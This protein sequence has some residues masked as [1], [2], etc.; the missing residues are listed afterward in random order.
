[1]KANVRPL[2]YL[3]ISETVTYLAE[4]AGSETALRW[5]A[6]V[7]ETIK[8]LQ[9]HPLLGRAR[10]DLPFPGIR[11]WRVKDFSRWLIFYCVRPKS[12]VFYRVKH[13]ATHLIALK[14]ES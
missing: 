6:A 3:D 10:P 1:M 5:S 12:L 14:F 11:T 4:Q 9:Q 7:W 13:G 8:E 2:F